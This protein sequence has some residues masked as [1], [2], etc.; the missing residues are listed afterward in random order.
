[1]NNFILAIAPVIFVVALG[2]FLAIRNVIAP[3]GWRGIERLVYFILFPVL[4]V[5][6]LA[7]APFETVP[8]GMVAAL[9]GAQILLGAVGVFSTKNGLRRAHPPTGSIIQSNVRWNTFVA[10]SLAGALFGETGLALV[11]VAAAAMIPVA[12]ILSVSG[13]TQFAETAQG[14]KK[15][16]L[17]DLAKNPLIIACIIGLGLNVTGL[18]PAGA[19]GITMDILGRA[20][21]ALGLLAAGAGVNF[22]A[23]KAAR[24]RT[25][26]WSVVRLIGLPALV[27]GIGMML[28]VPEMHLAV[29]VICAA[30]PTA[31]NGYILSQQLGGDAPLSANLIAAQTALAAITMPLMYSLMV[32]IR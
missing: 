18:V 27:L 13:L 23:L 31:T 4:I 25:F 30:T 10:L 1:M 12:N 3:E 28:S 20:T 14:T 7:K 29:A 21:I 5:T 26:L 17:K 32:L 11:A 19:V 9:M 16:V 22:T 24:T 8:W 15:N 2:R 6:V